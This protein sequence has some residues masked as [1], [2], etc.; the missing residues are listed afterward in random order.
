M[1]LIKYNPSLR[2]TAD[3]SFSTMLDSLF[4]E[5]FPT[6]SGQTA[7]SPQVD[8]AETKNDFQIELAVPGMK[9]EDFSIDMKKD[10]LIISGERKHA[11]KKDDKSYHSVETSYGKFTRS[12]FLPENIEAEN[13]EATYAD[14]ILTISIPKDEKKGLVKTIQI[15]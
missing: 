3:R 5:S 10:Q 14:G 6:Q 15:K 12:F 8:I 2:N 4:N 11:E 9:K 13:I 1:A 7:F